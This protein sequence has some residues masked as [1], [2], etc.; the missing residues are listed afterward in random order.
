MSLLEKDK[1]KFSVIIGSK[2]CG[3][4]SGAS[5]SVAA[6][7]VK[8]K[9]EAFYLKE[10][11][12]GSKKKLYG[13]YSSKKK[14]VQRGGEENTLREQI[15]NTVLEILRNCHRLRP[16]DEETNNKYKILENAYSLLGIDHRTDKCDVLKDIIRI[17]DN[18]TIQN[19]TGVFTLCHCLCSLSE[20]EDNIVE[21]HFCTEYKKLINKR[22]NKTKD[23]Y[24]IHW[25][26]FIN[27]LR[28]IIK[29]IESEKKSKIEEMLVR[30]RESNIRLGKL[31]S[32][33]NQHQI[34]KTRGELD[35]LKGIFAKDH[36]VEQ[37]SIFNERLAKLKS[38][39]STIRRPE[40]HA[41]PAQEPNSNNR[42]SRGFARGHAD[43]GPNKP[44]PSY[45]LTNNELAEI[46]QR[47][48]GSSLTS[49]K[50]L[51]SYAL[52]E[53]ELRELGINNNGNRGFAQAGP[54]EE[55]LNFNQLNNPLNNPLLQ[56][57][58]QGRRRNYNPN[59]PP[60]NSQKPPTSTN[61]LIARLEAIK[62]N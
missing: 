30:N 31:R 46:G 29:I 18:Y 37:D 40:Q 10:M 17:R 50:P 35:Q 42:R 2:K 22:L 16:V 32:E 12:K 19:K 36:F 9:S 53:N 7:K 44:L 3:A 21:I 15:C 54:A 55:K 62:N 59:Q 45:A 47:P 56:I 34:N 58:Y 6:K 41:G 20:K 14:V 23:F 24:S 27:F 33:F 48:N 25:L 11:T 51:P 43:S 61:N 5:P 13:P 4:C 49:H 1:R 52:N 26:K 60:H 8:G 38:T 28:N 39:M 57:K